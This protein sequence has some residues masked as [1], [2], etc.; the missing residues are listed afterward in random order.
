M[1]FQNPT[2][3]FTA[4]DLAASIPEVWSDIMMEEKFP[5]PTIVDFARDLSVYGSNGGDTIHVPDLFTNNFSAQDQSTQGNGIVDA[6]PAQV[7]VTLSIDTH[8][9]VAWI[10]GDKDMIQVATQFSLNEAYVR[11]SRSL[12]LQ[13]I[14]DDLYELW[15]GL[16]TNT[17]GDTA[18]QLTD[19]EIRQ[20]IEDLASSNYELGQCAFFFHTYVYWN[21]VLGIQKYYDAQQFG[22]GAPVHTG[23]LS[24]RPMSES[25]GY[26]GTLYG[27]PVYTSSRVVSGLQTY[28]NLLLHREAFG[29]AIQTPGGS[30]M[31]VQSDYLLQNLGLLVVVDVVYGVTELRDP[32]AVLLN[33]SSAYLVS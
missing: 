22:S 12:L 9:Y 20:G 28:R 14:E 10:I 16:T 1:A 21:Q 18:T 7:D 27:I 3:P 33:A 15:S 26:M 6:S 5:V 25:N 11:E 2:A 17:V 4:S 13:E 30:M 24:G 8:K 32:A 19:S 31:R 29:Y 23:T